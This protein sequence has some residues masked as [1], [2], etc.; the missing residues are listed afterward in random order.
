VTLM[1]ED[2]YLYQEIH[3]QPGALA[4]LIDRERD[5]IQRI[6]SQLSG[7][8]ITNV[9]VAARGTS[10]NAARYAQYLFGAV[11]RL[12]VGLATPSLFSIYNSPPRF[13]DALVI[14]ISQ[15]GSS[16]D[17]ISVVAAAREQGAL[18]LAISNEPDSLLGTSAEYVIALHAGHERS[19]AATKTYTTE[20]MALAL[21]SACLA[22]E[23]SMLE[24]L[25]E[26]PD[27]M[28]TVLQMSQ[29][30]SRAAER[31][32]YMRVCVVIGRGY[33]FATAFETAL[34]IKELTYV[35]AEPY[36][37]ADFLHGP[38]AL[39]EDAF[40][41]IVIAPS[42]EMTGAIIPFI[43]TLQQRGAEVVAIS[44]TP[45]VLE[46]ARVALRLPLTVSEWASPLLSIVPGQLFA[47]HLAHTRD[48]DVDRPRGITKV[49]ETN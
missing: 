11:N 5:N 26:I 30:I 46:R 17:I 41:A 37:S 6:A 18:T 31:Y 3:Q 21:L 43:E 49:T 14:G 48:Y 2:S 4:E 27:Q 47:M 32:R 9:F 20:L 23:A 19:V 7:R 1:L 24:T 22:D 10:D 40:P 33:N 12:P 25:Q 13:Q 28:R 42:G 45:A 44:D 8:R 39:V 34:K 36:S 35:L 29:A 16:P 15:S 38:V